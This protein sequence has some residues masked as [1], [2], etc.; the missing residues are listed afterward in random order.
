MFDGSSDCVVAGNSIG[1]DTTG[2]ASLRNNSGGIEIFDGSS[3][4]LIGGITAVA[5]NLIADNGGPGV[6]VG[7]SP[8]DAA[9]GNQITANRIFGNAGQAI[10]LGDDE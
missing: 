8:S 5:G 7:A 10:D 3:D 6:V 1:T 9:I 2:F 4:N